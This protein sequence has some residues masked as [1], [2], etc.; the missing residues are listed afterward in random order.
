MIARQEDEAHRFASRILLPRRYLDTITGLP[1]KQMLRAIE[2]AGVSPEAG[3]IGLVNAL[4]PGY[5]FVLL[6]YENTVD[7]WFASHGTVT[8]GVHRYGEFD[9]RHVG[10]VALEQDRVRMLGRSVWWAR[11]PE[12]LALAEPSEDWRTIL[13]VIVAD[14]SPGQQRSDA[15]WKSVSG[16]V[17]AAASAGITDSERLAALI[18]QR[19][20]NRRDLEPVRTHPRFADFVAARA[21]AIAEARR[22]KA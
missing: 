9:E 20:A 19:V 1:V 11:Y 7:S 8:F 6:S 18:Y 21:T 22:N 14:T 13:D 4:R 5:L 12:T 10:A 16:V 3:L 15:V 17:G 2:A